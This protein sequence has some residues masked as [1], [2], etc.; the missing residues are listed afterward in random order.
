MDVNLLREAA[1][2][3]SFL[4]FIGILVWAVHPAQ[5]RRFEAA[6]NAPFDEGEDATLSQGR[7][8]ERGTGFRVREH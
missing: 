6:A 2:V 3:V 5:R 8:G 7:G 1:T 4:T